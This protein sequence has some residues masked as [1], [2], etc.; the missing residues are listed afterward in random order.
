MKEQSGCSHVNVHPVTNAQPGVSVQQAHPQ[1][2]LAC[3]FTSARL[4]LFACPHCFCCPLVLL[5]QCCELLHGAGAEAGRQLEQCD[6][7]FAREQ[8][9]KVQGT[10]FTCNTTGP[11]RAQSRSHDEYGLQSSQKSCCIPTLGCRVGTPWRRPP[12]YHCT[13]KQR[14]LHCTVL[15]VCDDNARGAGSLT[16]VVVRKIQRAELVRSCQQ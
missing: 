12:N 2:H 7:G 14:S 15:G 1:P 10:L 4:C 3:E 16:D 9:H 11:A 5:Q 6:G 8:A 13:G